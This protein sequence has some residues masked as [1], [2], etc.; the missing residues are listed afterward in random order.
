MT[1]SKKEIDDEIMKKRSMIE[2]LR[3]QM[4]AMSSKVSEKEVD[5]CFKKI[6][7]LNKELDSLRKESRKIL[8]AQSGT[9]IIKDANM[10]L[11]CSVA[12]KGF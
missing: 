10:S 1:K 7:K 6:E 12:L 2:S 9:E 8:N 5:K 11:N 4:F 3:D